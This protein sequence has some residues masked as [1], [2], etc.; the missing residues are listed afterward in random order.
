MRSTSYGDAKCP[1]MFSL[2][3]IVLLTKI[4]VVE[5]E[6]ALSYDSVRGLYFLAVVFT[7]TIIY[8]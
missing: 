1:S 2:D 3:R 8:V 7:A 4:T 5:N 6:V